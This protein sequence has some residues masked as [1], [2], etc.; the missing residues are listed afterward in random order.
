[1]ILSFQSFMIFRKLCEIISRDCT[2]D[3]VILQRF[4][5]VYQSFSNCT[6]KH[7][8][9]VSGSFMRVILRMQYLDT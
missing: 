8:R 2:S 1:M 4:V 5:N 7:F 9:G 6:I 3:A